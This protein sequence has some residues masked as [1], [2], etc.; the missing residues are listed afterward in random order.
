MSYKRIK[1]PAFAVIGKQGATADGDGFIAR[2][3]EAA[4]AGFNE[5]AHL[6]K[7]NDDGSFAGFW[8]LMS[9]CGMNFLP[10]EDNFSKG[11]YLAGVETELSAEAPNGWVKW[12]S[13]GYE[14]IVAESGADSFFETLECI[15][16]EG[17]ELAG[18]VYDHTDPKTGE[19]FQFFP[20][21]KL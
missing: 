14:Y 4:N 16:H 21:S 11:L 17:L 18:A 9:D 3:W 7:K 20:I 8:G 6:A 13:P 5:V 2:L 1:K 15:K 19:S 10:W 12:V